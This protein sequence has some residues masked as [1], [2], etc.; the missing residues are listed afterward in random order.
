MH[1]YWCKQKDFK[2]SCLFVQ[3]FFLLKD[4]PP[5]STASHFVSVGPCTNEVSVFRLSFFCDWPFIIIVQ[6]GMDRRATLTV[7]LSIRVQVVIKRMNAQRG[8]KEKDVV[9][10]NKAY[11]YI[12]KLILWFGLDMMG[13]HGPHYSRFAAIFFSVSNQ[14]FEGSFSS[15]GRPVFLIQLLSFHWKTSHEWLAGNI[16]LWNSPAYGRSLLLSRLR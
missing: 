15:L 8:E 6:H 11:L 9:V 14:P 16:L 2:K 3:V 4:R 10:A 5:T 12:H 13:G 1:F 7:S